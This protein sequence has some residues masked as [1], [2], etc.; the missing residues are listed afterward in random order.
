M[1]NVS[2]GQCF[3]LLPPSKVIQCLQSLA[4]FIMRADVAC[5]GR[6]LH[7]G[8]V[9]CQK[10]PLPEAR[11]RLSCLKT[12]LHRVTPL[13]RGLRGTITKAPCGSDVLAPGG[14][15]VALSLFLVGSCHCCR[16][17]AKPYSKMK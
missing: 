3:S 15:E 5:F 7:R 11:I 16:L 12:P 2:T 13:V 6:G 9:S 10:W 1:S 14:E 17:Q 4:L 8:W